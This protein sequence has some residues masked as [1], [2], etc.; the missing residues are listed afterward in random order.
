MRAR[1]VNEAQNF[2]RGKDVKGTMGIGM[3][4]QIKKLVVG[5]EKVFT[6]KNLEGNFLVAAWHERYDLMDFIISQGLDING[7]NHEILR[8]LGWREQ[9]KVGVHLILKRGADI[10]GA[11][12]AAELKNEWK[13]ARRLEEMK[14]EAQ[15]HIATPVREAYHFERGMGPKGSMKIGGINLQEDFTFDFASLLERYV[16]KLQK[17]EGKT[18][19]CEVIIGHQPVQKTFKVLR[20]LEMGVRINNDSDIEDVIQLSQYVEAEAETETIY[21]LNLRSKIYIEK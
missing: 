14:E 8:V 6:K 21:Q 19:T 16:K 9:V 1:A 18:I 17:L 15:K 11:I 10:D 3:W 4:G 20:M 12:K 2:I 13:T 5:D 7:N